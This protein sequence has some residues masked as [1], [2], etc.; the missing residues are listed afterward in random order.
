MET[1]YIKRETIREINELQQIKA[2]FINYMCQSTEADLT[3][4]DLESC[5]SYKVVI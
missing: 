2:N 4:L 1:S 5:L 3:Y